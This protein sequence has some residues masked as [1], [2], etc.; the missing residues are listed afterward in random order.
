[1]KFTEWL[2]ENYSIDTIQDFFDLPE[3]R[4]AIIEAE[5]EKEVRYG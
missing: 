5:Y 3:V 2:K 4:Q 1:M